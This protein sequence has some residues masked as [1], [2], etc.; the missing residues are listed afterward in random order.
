[1]TVVMEW[2]SS[3]LGIPADA[4]ARLLATLGIILGLWIARRLGLAAVAKRTADPRLRYWWSKGSTYM[5]VAI[6]IILIGRLW[7]EG[8]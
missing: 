8:V 1:L 6:G 4:V 2:L 3:H 7:L 5:V